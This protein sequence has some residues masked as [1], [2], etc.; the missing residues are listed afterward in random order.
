MPHHI[1]ENK[2]RPTELD[3]AWNVRLH[4]GSASLEPSNLP[5]HPASQD[6]RSVEHL[7][8]FTLQNTSHADFQL[9]KKCGEQ[10]LQIRQTKGIR[11]KDSGC[12]GCSGFFSITFSNMVLSFFELPALVYANSQSGTGLEFS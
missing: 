2:G 3:S 10:P 1:A 6:A 9:W 7:K 11:Y 4:T 12:V 8:S 5:R